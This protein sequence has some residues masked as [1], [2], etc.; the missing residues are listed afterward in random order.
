MQ[1]PQLGKYGEL[2]RPDEGPGSASR[3]LGDL[4]RKLSGRSPSAR[5]R[6]TK[7]DAG[8]HSTAGTE[9]S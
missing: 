3:G 5:W 1:G 2:L 9:Q 7:T 8:K 4:D 6:L